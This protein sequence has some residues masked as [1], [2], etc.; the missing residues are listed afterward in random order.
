MTK[1][2]YY[3]VKKIFKLKIIIKKRECNLENCSTLDYEN[4]KKI[5]K[6]YK[7]KEFFVEK[8]NTNFCVNLCRHT[9]LK[10]IINETLCKITSLAQLDLIN[11]TSANSQLDFF[12]LGKLFNSCKHLK[13]L[14]FNLGPNLDISDHKMVHSDKLEY[15]RVEFKSS[16]VQTLIKFLTNCCLNV[17]HLELYSCYDESAFSLNLT[18][19]NFPHHKL[20]KLSHLVT[21]T[22]NITLSLNQYMFDLINKLDTFSLNIS[23]DKSNNYLS[24]L[25]SNQK[26]VKCD[27]NFGIDLTYLRSNNIVLNTNPYVLDDLVKDYFALDFENK[28][29][30]FKLYI[31]IWP[32]ILSKIDLNFDTT[33]YLNKIDFSSIHIHSKE[34]ICKLLS[35]LNGK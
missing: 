12:D 21:G 5:L 20:S 14:S 25:I 3:R 27:L 7:A 34:S 19:H 10:R 32:C 22:N 30:S 2:N 17:T 16:S 23:V 18:S 1:S 15:L 24:E 6:F 9:S 33:K 11:T 8:L 29:N 31:L 13:H 4:F 28:L 35:S 26:V